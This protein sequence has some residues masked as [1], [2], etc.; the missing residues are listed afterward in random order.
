[1]KKKLTKMSLVVIALLGATTNMDAFNY[2][3]QSM[4][5]EL[6]DITARIDELDGNGTTGRFL[7]SGVILPLTKELSLKLNDATEVKVDISEIMSNANGLT[8]EVL[9]DISFVDGKLIGTLTDDTSKNVTLP[10]IYLSSIGWDD[11]NRRM[12]LT[13]NNGVV[14]DVAILPNLN[15]TVDQPTK[16]IKLVLGSGVTKDITIDGWFDNFFANTG[17]LDLPNKKLIIGVDGAN[18]VEVDIST[19]IDKVEALEESFKDVAISTD[20]KTLTFNRVNGEDKVID[21]T[22]L[23]ENTKIVSGELKLDDKRIIFTDSDDSDVSV[24]ITALVDSIPAGKSIVEIGLTDYILTIK[25]S[26][27]VTTTIDLEMLPSQ[28]ILMSS[29]K[30]IAYTNGVITAKD[31]SNVETTIDISSLVDESLKTLVLDSSTLKATAFNGAIT[32][33]DLSTLPT[34]TATQTLIDNLT[35]EMNKAQKT[36]VLTESNLKFKTVDGTET[37][38]DLS[39]LPI[40]TL[41]QT[42]LDKLVVKEDGKGLTTNDLTDALLTKINDKKVS[43]IVGDVTKQKIVVSYTDGSTD[44]EI[45]LAFVD[46]GT[47]S[48][49]EKKLTLTRDGGSP[50]DVDLATLVDL[51]NEPKVTDLTGDATTK[52]ITATVSD[53]TTKEVDLSTWFSNNFLTGGS[54]DSVNKKMKLSVDGKPDV[55]VDVADL[56]AKEVLDVVL[57][58]TDNTLDVSYTDGS[59]LVALALPTNINLDS[60][61][62]DKA[63]KNITFNISDGTTRVVT[64]V[65]DKADVGLGNVDDTSD[66]DKPISTATQTALSDKVNVDGAKVLSEN[67]FT[68]DLK[69]L[70]ESKKVKDTTLDNGKIKVDYSDGTSANLVLPSSNDVDTV[71]FDDATKKVKITLLD[72]TAKEITLS[73]SKADVGLGNADNTS[74]ADKPV[75]TATQTE[76]DKLVVKDGVKVLSDN[77]LTDA[78]KDAIE[79]KKVKDVTFVADKLKIDFT[80]GTNTELTPPAG[81]N[82]DTVAFDDA[83]KK[84][85]FTL[86][87]GVTKEVILSFNKSDVGLGDVDNTSDANKPI[88]TATQTALDLKINVDG[89]KVLTTNDFT[90]ALKTLLE[91]KKV[92]NVEPDGANLK[93]TFTDATNTTI[94]LPTNINL[95]SVGYDKPTKKLTFALTDGTTKDV[96]LTLDK[97]DLGLGNVDD[98]SDLDKPISTATLTALN[99]KVNTDGAKVLSENDF[100]TAL[101]TAVEL[102]KVLNVEPDG[103]NLK[104][105]F[106]DATEAMLNIPTNVNLDS[107]SFNAMLNKVTYVLTNG[108]NKEVILSF[109]KADVGLGNVDNTSDVNKPISTATQ[110]ALGDKVNVDGAKVLTTN[111]LTNDLKTLLEKKKVENTTYDSGANK[112]TIVYTD[113]TTAILDLATVTNINLDSVAYD[114]PTK[115]LTF[116]LTDGTN[117]EVTLVIAK[118]DIGLANVDNTSDADK[119]ISSLTQTALDS[120]VNVDGA[121]VL[122]TNDFT[123]ALKTAVEAK[124]VTN[125]EPDGTNLKVTY[126]DGTDTSVALPININVNA[127]AYDATTKKITLTL[128]DGA[129]KI[130]DLISIDEKINKVYQM[131]MGNMRLTTGGR[132]GWESDKLTND[133]RFI[134][135][136]S[137]GVGN[138]KSGYVA[139]TLDT[140][141]TVTNWQIAYL[142]LTDAQVA[143][144]SSVYVTTSDVLL[145][146]HNLYVPSLNHIILGFK[147]GDDGRFIFANGTDNHSMGADTVLWGEKFTQ[148]MKNK[149]TSIQDNS[150]VNSTLVQNDWNKEI[151]FDVASKDE[152]PDGWTNINA[153][154]DENS[155]ILET[156]PYG[157][158]DYVWNAKTN[159]VDGNSGVNADGGSNSEMVDIDPTKTY[160]FSIWVQRDHLTD[161]KIYMGTH[162]YNGAS[163]NL[164]ETATGNSTTN[165]YFHNQD[166]VTANEWY[167][168]VGYINKVGTPNGTLAKGGVYKHGDLTKVGTTVD[169]TFVGTDVTQSMMR[170]YNYYCEIEGTTAKFYNPRMEA[171]D[172]TQTPLDRL[173]GAE[174]PSVNIQSDGNDLALTSDEAQVIKLFNPVVIPSGKRVKLS[175]NVP[176]RSDVTGDWGGYYLNVNVKVNDT[177]YNL[178]NNGYN[179]MHDGSRS[180]TTDKLTRVIDFPTWEGVEGMYTLQVELTGKRYGTQDILI[181]RIHDINRVANGLGDR[182]ALYTNGS[183]QNWLTLTT[184]IL[185]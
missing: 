81:V 31:N 101:K 116:A 153:R 174:I 135:I 34:S 181:N 44:T 83:T 150:I 112:I 175:I 167:L 115:K 165:P 76:L 2:A 171:M 77:S 166:V 107:V 64:L 9:K 124:K 108:V 176:T 49:T 54:L 157:D 114:Q 27:N 79:L 35:T 8:E 117:K 178:G 151:P 95:D 66:A 154:T 59:P 57:N 143:A 128:T 86:T 32:E 69:T 156:T 133:K 43:A 16:T 136:P 63:T 123:T 149:I 113:G 177:W 70:L 22:M 52:K 88:S 169:F 39:T 159:N 82:L 24:D 19:L 48:L 132:V 122:T 68:N 41:V 78:L 170:F 26:D 17:T 4:S 36:I 46:G 162:A 139:L 94:A 155:I 145:A 125:V 104:V 10:D 142:D 38:I 14:K 96:T 147:N 103:T 129:T 55:E 105:T 161:G 23:T 180:I 71:T 148:G 100:T 12:T 158:M 168:V 90:D 33:I 130:V 6:K 138:I 93:V 119:P 98:T 152:Y 134:W 80:D 141:L 45:D 75:S 13:L 28:A 11:A 140:P 37:V 137:I 127:S 120:K 62:Y 20:S 106:T 118:G 164:K 183:N 72:G 3:E 40:S 21:L 121:K 47:F 102:K 51:A 89:A 50:F 160:R 65:I 97:A 173:I 84:V 146:S 179:N 109:D 56:F 85:T 131:T 91:T 172:G 42:E 144:D 25:D 185:D 67:D 61:T 73:F 58:A 18:D 5:S 110:T 15:L 92:T 126:T 111:D 87:N 7:E 182:G 99:D 184:E 163:G 29:L 60:A 1:M 30:A 74:D 53:G